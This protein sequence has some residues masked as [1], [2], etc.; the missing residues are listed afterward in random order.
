MRS[1][2]LFLEGASNLDRSILP[3]TLG[4]AS[5]GFT[6]PAGSLA[7]TFSFATGVCSRGSGAGAAASSFTSATV[8]ASFSLT[9]SAAAS[10]SEGISSSFSGRTSSGAA[11]IGDC[12]CFSF[13]FTLP[14]PTA[15]RSILPMMLGPWS[16]F[17][18]A[19]FTSSSC[20][21]SE[22]LASA[23]FGSIGAEMTLLLMMTS[24]RWSS[25]S[26]AFF[27]P[28]WSIISFSLV[29]ILSASCLALRSALN[30][31]S[32]VG[33]SSSDIFMLG[34]FSTSTPLDERN[35]TSVSRPMPNCLVI[36]LNLISAMFCLPKLMIKNTILQ[37]LVREYGIHPPQSR[38]RGLR[39]APHLQGQVQARSWQCRSLCP[40]AFR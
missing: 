10:G 39:G 4:P 8:S 7:S 35:S 11:E 17:S 29:L 19:A 14:L 21:G 6:L 34:F 20:S 3:T 16:F 38:P 22:A 18:G 9:S 30:F 26:S 24:L 1:R 37:T 15:S 40:E 2:F 27:F 36:L 5:L 33:S 12:S 31:A 23:A 13:A 28:A 32:I 25:S